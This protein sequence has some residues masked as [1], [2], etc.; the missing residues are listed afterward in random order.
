MVLL[1]DE[2]VKFYANEVFQ[3][4]KWTNNTEHYINKLNKKQSI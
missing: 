3:P 2:L 1:N 4:G